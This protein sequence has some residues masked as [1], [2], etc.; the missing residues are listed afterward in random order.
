MGIPNIAPWGLLHDEQLQRI[1]Q[2]DA[3]VHASG[4]ITDLARHWGRK[5]GALVIAHQGVVELQDPDGVVRAESLAALHAAVAFADEGAGPSKADRLACAI[6]LLSEV[7]HGVDEEARSRAQEVV[8]NLLVADPVLLHPR[9]VIPFR[10]RTG[11]TEYMPVLA[12]LVGSRHGALP[13]VRHGIDETAMRRFATSELARAPFARKAPDHAWMLNHDTRSL[14]RQ[15]VTAS[16][17]VLHAAWTLFGSPSPAFVSSLLENRRLYT[18]GKD[19]VMAGRK[20]RG[21]EHEMLRQALPLAFGLHRHRGLLGLSKSQACPAYLDELKRSGVLLQQSFV[22]S[23]PHFLSEAILVKWMTARAS[24]DDGAPS[25]MVRENV[26]LVLGGLVECGLAETALAAAGWLYDEVLGDTRPPDRALP[27]TGVPSAVGFLQGLADAGLN[28]GD[29]P[30]NEDRP[31]SVK[32]LVG[33]GARWQ[34][35]HE[36]CSRQQAMELVLGDE[37]ATQCSVPSR[38]RAR[39]V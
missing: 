24:W 2:R 35:A 36:V 9:L 13:S 15:E 34:V 7:E 26:R 6:A 1:G 39:I 37:P 14:R 19:F 3:L 20:M 18:S 27:E 8:S 32:S 25:E 16:G 11:W 33:N 10:R 31:G 29:K 21:N 5:E 38:R 23:L 4:A 17:E 28:L 12:A 22:N 30:P